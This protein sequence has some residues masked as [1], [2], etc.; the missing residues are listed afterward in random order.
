MCV[1]FEVILLGTSFDLDVIIGL[2]LP[3][4]ICGP[5]LAVYVLSL[6]KQVFCYPGA[7]Q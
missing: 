1:C 5:E 2:A 7:M 3:S 6:R 4:H